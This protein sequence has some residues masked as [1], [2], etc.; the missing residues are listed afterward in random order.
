MVEYCVRKKVCLC[1][2]KTSWKLF[3]L[4]C[5]QIWGSFFDKRN[6]FMGQRYVF[7]DIQWLIATEIIILNVLDFELLLW[8]REH[9]TGPCY[10]VSQKNVS[11]SHKFSNRVS[12][13]VPYPNMRFF[14]GQAELFWGDKGT[15]FYFGTPKRKKNPHSETTTIQSSQRIHY[16]KP[17]IC[18]SLCYSSQSR[19]GSTR[20]KTKKDSPLQTMPVK[21]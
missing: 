20:P 19:F 1:P 10:R 3:V 16:S 7:W 12:L 14:L 2:I 18:S 13:V 5:S 21:I 6:F 15:F 11:L 4:C 8:T 9:W 17:S